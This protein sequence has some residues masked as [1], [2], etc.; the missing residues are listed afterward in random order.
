MLFA[1]LVVPAAQASQELLPSA[2]E[3]RPAGQAT[4][5][6]APVW[7][8]S[9]FVPAA[10]KWPAAHAWQAPLR[11]LLYVLAGQPLRSLRSL[12]KGHAPTRVVSPAC[13]PNRPSGQ[14][15]QLG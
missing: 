11:L 10:V 1:L 13:V 14:G 3:M 7:T 12:W 4:Q 2:L 5:C 6:V 9:W 15:V 8:P